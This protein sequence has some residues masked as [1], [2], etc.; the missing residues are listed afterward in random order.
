MLTLLQ[1]ECTAVCI[2]HFTIISFTFT[3]LADA[4][5]KVT[6]NWGQQKQSKPKKKAII[7]KCC[8]TVGL[9]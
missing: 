6:Y 7:C 8:D 3:H 2:L 4:L 5:S 9:L 1:K